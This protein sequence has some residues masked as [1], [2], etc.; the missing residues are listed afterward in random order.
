MTNRL[1]IRMIVTTVTTRR[2]G[3]FTNQ[4]QKNP[5][6]KGE[7]HSLILMIAQLVSAD[8]GWLAN[9]P[10]ESET[11]R[12]LFRAGKAREDYFDNEQYSVTPNSRNGISR[13]VLSD[14]T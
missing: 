10:D 4:K 8:Y 14:E 2:G 13:K 5:Y 7:G 12:I 1:F 9:S 3:G 6:P 11:A